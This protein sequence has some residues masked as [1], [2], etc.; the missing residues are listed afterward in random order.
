MSLKVLNK[1]KAIFEVVIDSELI[2]EQKNLV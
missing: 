1:S 2:I